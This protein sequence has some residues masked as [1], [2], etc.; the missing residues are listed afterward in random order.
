M[1]IIAWATLA[2]FIV[3]HGDAEPS[4]LNWYFTARSRRWRT[5]AEVRESFG[6]ADQVGRFT[7]L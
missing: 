3:K 4:I 2:A 6:G 5:F 7:V 1:R